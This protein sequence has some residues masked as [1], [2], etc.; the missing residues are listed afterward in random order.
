MSKYTEDQYPVV[1][2]KQDPLIV[3]VDDLILVVGSSSFSAKIKIGTMYTGFY[4]HTNGIGEP[5][6]KVSVDINGISTQKVNNDFTSSDAYKYI[7]DQAAIWMDNLEASF[8]D[9]K[10]QKNLVEIIQEVTKYDD[11]IE[12]TG[13][14]QIRVE[15]NDD[16]LEALDNHLTGGDGSGGIINSV[17]ESIDNTNDTLSDT[18]SVLSNIE[19][20]IKGETETSSI[21]SDIKDT[22]DDINT[23]LGK[24]E[25]A[26][27]TGNGTFAKLIADAITEGLQT[28]TTEMSTMNTNIEGVQNSIGTPSGDTVLGLVRDIPTNTEMNTAIDNQSTDIKSAI[29]ASGGSSEGAISGVS[30]QIT[31]LTNTVNTMNGTVNN[32]KGDTTN[33]KASAS[34]TESYTYS[35]KNK[36]DSAFKKEDNTIGYYVQTEL[37]NDDLITGPD[38]DKRIKATTD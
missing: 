20:A 10:G 13:I 23:T 9:S 35:T 31:S 37:T 24:I 25:E 17:K 30:Q 11:P 34:N 26:M 38:D 18:N 7:A 6:A 22:L 21:L 1:V 19:S 12:G 8:V 29:S 28:L 3:R 4:I 14:A 2:Y 36:V 32:I 15:T 33:I 27:G 5:I 16:A